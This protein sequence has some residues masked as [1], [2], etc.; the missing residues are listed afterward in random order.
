MKTRIDLSLNCDEIYRIRDENEEGYLK[1]A[2]TAGRLELMIN[3]PG[4]CGIVAREID[5]NQMYICLG[6]VEEVVY[7]LNRD[8]EM[9]NVFEAFKEKINKIEY[10]LPPLTSQQKLNNLL[11]NYNKK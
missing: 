1:D 8:S 11:I 6:E 3:L 2:L 5:P 10:L 9:R 4:G 7:E